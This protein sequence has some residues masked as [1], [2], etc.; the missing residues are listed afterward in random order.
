MNVNDSAKAELTGTAEQCEVHYAA[1]SM[2]NH[3][4]LISGQFI[5]KVNNKADDKNELDE[6][7]VL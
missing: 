6:L 5:Q 2:V 7:A 4:N 1:G 3:V